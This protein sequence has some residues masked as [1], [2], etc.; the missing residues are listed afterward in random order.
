[1]HE[2]ATRNVG[3]GCT[4]K[5]NPNCFISKQ[6]NYNPTCCSADEPCGLGQGG[7][8]FNTDCWDNLQCHENTCGLGINGSCC[9]T[10]RRKPGSLKNHARMIYI[11]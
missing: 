11:L 4:F 10:P 9:T 5:T 3:G 1:M 7:C 8:E 2:I 6:S